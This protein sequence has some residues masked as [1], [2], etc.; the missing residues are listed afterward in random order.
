[1]ILLLLFGLIPQSRIVGRESLMFL[2]TL[3]SA[4]ILHSLF[5]VPISIIIRMWRHFDANTLKVTVRSYQLIHLPKFHLSH[6]IVFFPVFEEARS[7]C[8]RHW[9]TRV[10]GLSQ[11]GPGSHSAHLS[12]RGILKKVV[13]RGVVYYILK[14]TPVA[15]QKSLW[16]NLRTEVWGCRGH[17][18]AIGL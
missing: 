18:E 8:S 7:F 15:T 2:K 9:W 14:R 3:S 5:V 13:N 1:M 4:L 17:F 16:A 11:R 6:I 10:G 12:W